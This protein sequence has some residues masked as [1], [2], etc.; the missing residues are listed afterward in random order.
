MLE[1]SSLMGDVL[2]TKFFEEQYNNELNYIFNTF[3]SNLK[4]VSE[5]KK[6]KGRPVIACET[7]LNDVS[8]ILYKYEMG[9]LIF[10]PKEIDLRND[11]LPIY[12]LGASKSGIGFTI[13]TK[14]KNLLE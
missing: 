2:M 8:Y 1:Y 5:E 12:F 11:F 9:K 6:I 4:I 14:E 10:V 7:L 13:L 3:F